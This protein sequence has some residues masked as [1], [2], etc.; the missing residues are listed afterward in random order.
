MEGHGLEG[1]GY[2]FSSLGYTYRYIHGFKGM[3]Y[4]FLRVG[5]YG[6]SL[7]SLV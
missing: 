4:H 1:T 5:V 3:G 6:F 2:M 7:P